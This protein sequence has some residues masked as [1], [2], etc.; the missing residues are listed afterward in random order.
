[1]DL[2]KWKLGAYWHNFRWQAVG[3][4]FLT[5]FSEKSLQHEGNWSS[6]GFHHFQKPLHHAKIFQWVYDF[7]HRHFLWKTSQEIQ[8]IQTIGRAWKARHCLSKHP[9]L[10]MLLNAFDH[11]TKIRQA[12]GCKKQCEKGR[13]VSLDRDGFNGFSQK[14]DCGR[15]CMELPSF[16][17]GI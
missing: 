7:S 14:G 2:T 6:I 13:K 12:G 9:L 11:Y 1:M 17:M 16:L 15:N 8:H 10:S 4:E 3:A 5:W